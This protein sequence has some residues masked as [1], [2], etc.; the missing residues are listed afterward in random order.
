MPSVWV[1]VSQRDNRLT[2]F[3][4]FGRILSDVQLPFKPGHVAVLF[5]CE[6]AEEGIEVG[7]PMR[8]GKTDGHEAQGFG[9]LGELGD[10]LGLLHVNFGL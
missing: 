10:Y 1:R 7:R 8:P 3:K 5:F 9:L 6:T 4:Q 2:A